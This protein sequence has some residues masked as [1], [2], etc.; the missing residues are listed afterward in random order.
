MKILISLIALLLSLNLFADSVKVEVSPSKPVAGE[1]FQAIFRVFTDS[2]EEPSINFT[3]LR[4]EVVGKSNQGIKTSTIYANGQFTSTREMTIVYDLAA[5]ATGTA[6]LRDITVQVEGKTIRHPAVTFNVLK[7]PEV[8]ADVFV[9]AEV[10]KTTV[11]VGEGVVV[12]YFL[13][14][15]TPV[16][17][18][19]IKKYPKL[20]GFL[21]RFLQEPERSERVSVDGQLYIRT[22]LYAAKL[23]PEKMGELKIDPLQLTATITV[24]QAADPF[25]TFGFG[26]TSKLRTIQSESIKLEVRPLP[27]AGRSE[28]FTGLVGKHEFD[29]Q[30]NNS[31]LI[32]NEPLEVKLTVS[33]NGALENLE[34]PAILKHQDLEEFESNG[35]LKIMDADQATKVFDYTFLPKA[36]MS[37][38]ATSVNLSY[39]DPDTSRYVAVQLPM[40]EIVVAGASQ[41]S[42]RHKPKEQESKSD[43]SVKLPQISNEIAGPILAQASGWRNWL[44]YLNVVLAILALSIALSLV[45]KRDK[46]PSF[47]TTT[48]P[49]KFKKG[50]FELGE[51]VKWLSPL[52]AK[53]GKS[54]MVLIIES[55][56]S[57]DAKTYFIDLLKSNDYKDYA[58]TKGQLKY[59][60]NSQ[61][62]KE[63]DKYIQSVTNEN[64][65]QPS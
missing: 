27:E 16:R 33:G 30:V 21:K 11:F 5:T 38:P 29:L 32:V 61:C 53:T 52:I 25:G 34:A 2:D 1:V 28:A 13:Y 12:R 57:S 14:H 6:G 50:Q 42:E 3:P 45:L 65:S 58:H 55:D 19:D 59:N 56:L 17:N 39:F 8:A 4:V 51:F 64:S 7:E 15:K 48:I 10:P 47:S 20:N 35:D 9:M 22:Q 63:L 41:K 26:G 24:N 49:A 54:P 43:T 37:I 44:S 18:V 23:F 46:L 40:P 62:F 31:K 36:N 60:Y